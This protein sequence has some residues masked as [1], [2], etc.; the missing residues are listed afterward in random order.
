MLY[1]SMFINYYYNPYLGLGEEQEWMISTRT[2][3]DDIN[4]NK[5]G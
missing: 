2:R 3:M 1:Y 4:K 5:N